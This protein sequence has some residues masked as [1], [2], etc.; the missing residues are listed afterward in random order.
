MQIYTL[1]VGQGQFGVVTSNTEA[2]IVDTSIQV[3]PDSAN[4]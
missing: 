2:V 3:A 4:N 1:N